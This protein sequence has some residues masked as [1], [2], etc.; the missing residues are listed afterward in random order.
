M[1]ITR[2]KGFTLKAVKSKQYNTLELESKVR[3]GSNKWLT[4]SKVNGRKEKYGIDKP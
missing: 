2:Q 1:L 4:S 3:Y